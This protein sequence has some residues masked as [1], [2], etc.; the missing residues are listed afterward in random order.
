L[1]LNTAAMRMLDYVPFHYCPRCGEARLQ[2]N[3]PK[4]FICG[5]CGFIYYHGASTASVGIIEYE[6]KIIITQR[7]NEPQKGGLALPGGFVDYDEDMESA[8]IREMQEEL[9]LS[10]TAPAYLCSHGERY[11]SGGVTYFVAIAFFVARV[12]DISSITARDDISAFRLVRLD[13]IKGSEL[14]FDSDRAA[15][16]EYR[17]RKASQECV[18]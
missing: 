10:I 6:D 17:K 3:D 13:E 7:A 1:S 2:P 14:A 15:L 5:S 11:P 18:A 8:L 16:A 9:N 12:S 4:S